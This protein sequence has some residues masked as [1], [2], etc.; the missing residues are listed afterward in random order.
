MQDQQTWCG[1][2]SWDG[3]V[4]CTITKTLLPTFWEIKGKIMSKAYLYAISC[5]I[6]KLGVVV[7]HGMVQCHTPLLGHSD[8]LFGRPKENLVQSLLYK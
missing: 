4:L 7:H 2:T 3:A 5:G 8:L 6:T 1:S